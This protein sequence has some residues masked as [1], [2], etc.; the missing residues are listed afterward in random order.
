MA[1]L[2]CAVAPRSLLPSTSS[3]PIAGHIGEGREGLTASDLAKE[4]SG[5]EAE[6]RRVRIV[7]YKG[8]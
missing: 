3:I 7:S 8:T 5:G 1:L 6:W 4:R 2:A